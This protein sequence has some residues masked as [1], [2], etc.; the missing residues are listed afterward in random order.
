MVVFQAEVSVLLNFPAAVVVVAV[1]GDGGGDGVV[2]VAVEWP[3]VV[4]YCVRQRLMWM[5]TN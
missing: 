1:G 3:F 2:D 4:G 5:S